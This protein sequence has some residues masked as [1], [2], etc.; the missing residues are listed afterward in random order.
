MKQK[1]M[2]QKPVETL[3]EAYDQEELPAL[4]RPASDEQLKEW[5]TLLKE[6][7]QRLGA[8]LKDPDPVLLD[9][10]KLDALEDR[11]DAVYGALLDVR[12]EQEKRAGQILKKINNY[13]S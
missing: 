6:E 7:D 10:D 9:M 8:L 12:D 4:L 3:I 5:E 11:Q 13:K 1:P 2:K